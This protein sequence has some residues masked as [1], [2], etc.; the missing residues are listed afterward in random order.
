MKRFNT[1]LSAAAAT[2]MLSLAPLSIGHAQAVDASATVASHGDWTLKQREDW[3]YGR[4]DKARDEGAL[5]H[6]EYDHVRGRLHAIRD[7]EDRLRDQHDGQ[8]TDNETAELETRL[9][10][11]ADQIHW[12]HEQN[13]QRPW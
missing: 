3:L 11:V 8:L 7:D 12:L 5:G 13:F 1:I 4:L 9:D 2:A 6:D 10:N